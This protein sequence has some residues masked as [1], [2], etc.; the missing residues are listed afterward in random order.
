MNKPV[1]IS[2]L[3][4]S[5]VVS[6]L[7]WVCAQ[8]VLDGYV[9]A[10]RAVHT[11]GMVPEEGGKVYHTFV[12]KNPSRTTPLIISRVIADCGCTTPKWS[13][14]P[15]APGAT[16]KIHVAFDPLGR[17]GTFVKYI[18]VY[19]NQTEQPIELSIKGNVSTNGTTSSTDKLY[20]QV[21]GGVQVS[22]AELYFPILQP[23]IEH[24]VRLV[25][26]NPTNQT[27]EVRLLEIPEFV[28]VS[29]GHFTLKPQEPEQIYITAKLTDNAPC[30][31]LKNHM[32]IEVHPLQGE[33]HVGYISTI[34]PSVPLFDPE[35]M[36][37]PRAQF[38]SYIR[39]G[40]LSDFADD[41]LSGTVD[42]E[43]AGEAMMSICSVDSEDASIVV[44]GFSDSIAPGEKGQIRYTID[45]NTLRDKGKT[46]S[47]NIVLVL[48]DPNGPVR[49]IKLVLN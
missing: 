7:S 44:D 25:V 3:I 34:L 47:G 32:Q 10:E 8:S 48:N 21:I 11:F 37:T 46:L 22:N 4:L 1:R 36:K 15:I 16:T 38:N 5:L 6:S 42:I 41:Y 24:V 17:P 14:E 45:L 43:N 31:L 30:G 26:N 19:N 2:L 23:G 35:A 18:F 27:V 29:K 12:L 33:E 40:R 9:P 49:K 20:R 39:L 13:E 28:S